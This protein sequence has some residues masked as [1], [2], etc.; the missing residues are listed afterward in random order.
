MAVTRSGTAKV[1][2]PTDEEILITREFDA[3]RA[4]VYKA[5][6]TPELVG[7]WWAGR[8]GVMKTVDIDLRVGGSWR[9]VM[10]AQGGFEV[11][12]HGEYRELEPEQRIVTTEV[13]EGAP[14]SDA[15]DVLNVDH[16]LRGR[17]PHDARAARAVPEPRDPRRDHGLGHGGRDAGAV[18]R[19]R[20]ARR[21]ARLGGRRRRGEREARRGAR[22][23]DQRGGRD[24]RAGEGD[25][26]HGGAGRGGPCRR[27]GRRRRSSRRPPARP[28]RRPG[29]A[30]AACP[31]RRRSAAARPSAASRSAGP[32]ASARRRGRSAPMNTR[33]CQS[34]V[35][36]SKVAK[37]SAPS[38]SSAEC[39]RGSACGTRRGA[40][41]TAPATLTRDDQPEQQRVDQQARVGGA[42]VAHALEVARQQQHAREQA[43][44]AERAGGEQRA[45]PPVGE[46][47]QRDDRRRGAA[48]D[49]D[50]RRRSSSPRRSG[51][52]SASPPS[53]RRPRVR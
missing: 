35:A 46:Q 50:E 20:G 12:F 30:A 16:V 21:R 38:A 2:L 9:Y 49:A 45:R 18:R 17:R 27:A 51:R 44:R 15:G 23:G 32:R 22:Q 3:P 40:T 4:L 41:I 14:P 39:R 8:R 10:E 28:R 37:P 36:A 11:A 5:W 47:R 43:E 42:D 6:T 26:G 7:R 52:R 24:D 25:D 19:A 31:S 48:L 33:L 13:F 29:A 1:T 53:A 34:G